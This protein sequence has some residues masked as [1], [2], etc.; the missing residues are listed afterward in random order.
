[1]TIESASVFFIDSILLSLG[2]LVLLC[3]VILVNN[4]LAKYWKPVRLYYWEYRYLDYPEDAKEKLK[5]G[6]KT[7]PKLD[8]VVEKPPSKK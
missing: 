8:T 1:M 6:E 7:E 4:L 5:N 2:T 3:L